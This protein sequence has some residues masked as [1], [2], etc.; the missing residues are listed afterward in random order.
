LGLLDFL[1]EEVLADTGVDC[2]GDKFVLENLL[3]EVT[4]DGS[5]ANSGLSLN[6]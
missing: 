6:N 2:M 1:A 4:E 5:F 3:G